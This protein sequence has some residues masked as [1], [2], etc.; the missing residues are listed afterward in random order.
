MDDVVVVD[1]D[2]DEAWDVKSFVVSDSFSCLLLVFVGAAQ[3]SQCQKDCVVII[4]FWTI[5]AISE[6]AAAAAAA[7]VVSDAFRIS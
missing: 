1:E 2:D 4:V 6:E 3:R 5:G 7:A